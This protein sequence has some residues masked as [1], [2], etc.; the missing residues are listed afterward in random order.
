MPTGIAARPDCYRL[1]GNVGLILGL[2]LDSVVIELNVVGKCAAQRG[3][4][5]PTKQHSG[6][7][8]RCYPEERHAGKRNRRDQNRSGSI[9]LPLFLCDELTETSA[10]YAQ[11]G[12]AFK[13]N[14][15][16]YS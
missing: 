4:R 3:I 16:G 7:R 12:I 9:H 11:F 13:A 1:D 2:K 8:Q 15:S 10:A 6:R 14:L 5:T